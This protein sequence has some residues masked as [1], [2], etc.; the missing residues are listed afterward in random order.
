[1]SDS[2]EPTIE[3]ATFRNDRFG[4]GTARFPTIAGATGKLR[5]M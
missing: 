3:N 1:M 2:E 4:N 5:C